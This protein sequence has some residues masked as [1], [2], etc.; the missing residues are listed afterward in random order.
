MKK[1]GL[2]I[3]LDTQKADGLISRYTLDDREV[4]GIRIENGVLTAVF[5]TS[6]R[7]IPLSVCAKVTAQ[8]RVT[9]ALTSY[10]AELFVDGELIDEEWFYGDVLLFSDK[11][12]CV[13]GD[14][15]KWEEYVEQ[16]S[17]KPD[18]IGEFDNAYGFVPSDRVNVG[19]CMPFAH[20]GVYHLFYLK[21][22]R[23]H[24][25]K[26]G[27]GA[28]E[29]AHISTSD[30]V[31]WRVHPNAIEIDDASQGS[32]C[33]GSVIEKD[34][35]FYA[36]YTVRMSDGSPAPILRSVSHDCIH[37]EKDS[38]FG[39][40]LDERYHAAS[41]RDPKV[42][43]G[44]DGKYHMLVT[45]SLSDGSNTGALAHL[46]SDDIDKWHLCDAPFITTDTYV[47]EEKSRFRQPECADYFYHNG[48]YYLCYA[49]QAF[50]IYLT[51]KTPFDGF[52]LPNAPVIPC[53]R[54]P[55]MAFF[56]DRIIF[57]GFEQDNALG[58]AGSLVFTEAHQ[59]PD[60]TLEFSTP[61]EME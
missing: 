17:E 23:H 20:D 45:T 22:R 38:S 18:V 36:F 15:L 5:L 29:W 3:C 59:K 58:Y 39:F 55:K 1:Q 53:G 49:P 57:A 56:G 52:S 40:F 9:L 33:T 6:A 54:V 2:R 42:F 35:V 34:G 50:S 27:L 26:W 48:Y 19:D 16:V 44:A 28:H 10:K 51:S 21:D 47:H 11:A 7:D 41:A 37:F 60:G 30:L 25:S 46:V 61:K 31:H 4:F 43:L 24:K 32:I 12:V 8:S 14:A 13:Q